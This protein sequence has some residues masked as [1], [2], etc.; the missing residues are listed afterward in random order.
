LHYTFTFILSLVFSSF[1]FY[2]FTIKPVS[3]LLY[4]YGAPSGSYLKQVESSK[5]IISPGYELRPGLI[6]LVQEHTFSGS[7]SENSYSHLADF[8]QTCACLRIEGMA[9]ETLRC[10]LFPFSLM[11]EAKHWYNRHVGSSQGDWEV[12][13]SNFC[14]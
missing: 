11:G 9:D 10:K 5:P 7:D 2:L 1:C 12:L 8:E 13:C 6:Q 3:Q 4:Q 14:L